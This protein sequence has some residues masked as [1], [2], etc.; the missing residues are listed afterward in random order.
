MNLV[1][2]AQ[3]LKYYIDALEF[4]NY[5]LRNALFR[6]LEDTDIYARKIE[7]RPLDSLDFTY[8]TTGEDLI[9]CKLDCS[10]IGINS[11]Q[12]RINQLKSKI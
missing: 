2:Q 5:R 1:D 4:E 6:I 7:Y 11:A 12:D 9:I 8:D 3:A 10:K